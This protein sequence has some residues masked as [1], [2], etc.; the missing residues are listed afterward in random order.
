MYSIR[1]MHFLE[2]KQCCYKPIGS[3]P[4]K[5]NLIVFEYYN[6]SNWISVLYLNLDYSSKPAISFPTPV[7]KL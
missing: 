3:V 6:Q 7:T 1:I 4:Q 2:N 5:K